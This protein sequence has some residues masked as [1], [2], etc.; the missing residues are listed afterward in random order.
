M[1]SDLG[2]CIGMGD[3]GAVGGGVDGVVLG[4]QNLLGRHL[5]KGDGGCEKDRSGR[6]SHLKNCSPYWSICHMTTVYDYL[7][8]YW[9][10]GAFRGAP[11]FH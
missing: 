4:V 9:F 5:S 11:Q 2:G 1:V 7:D 3:G 8:S 6:E 10:I